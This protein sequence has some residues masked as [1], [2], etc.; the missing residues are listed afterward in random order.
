M[1]KLVLTDVT[2]GYTSTTATNNNNALI[3]AAL[4][5]T[6]SRDGTAPNQMLADL[7][8]N[9]KNLLNVKNINGIAVSG[10]TDLSAYTNAAESSAIAAALSEANAASSAISATASAVESNG[11][12]V[13]AADSAASAAVIGAMALSVSNAYDFGFVTETVNYFSTDFGSII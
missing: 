5:N 10:L 8:L 9:S 4:E 7:D 11:Y 2:S 1:A 12:A 3:E 13:S 6:L